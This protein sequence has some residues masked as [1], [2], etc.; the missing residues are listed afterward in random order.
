[1]KK[2]IVVLAFFIGFNANAGLINVDISNPTVSVGGTTELSILGAGFDPF[3]TFEFQL[4]FDTSLFSIDLVSMVSDL[5][6]ASDFIFEVT[7]Q[8]YG[9]ALSFIN[10][11]LFT[12][13]EFIAAKINLTAIAKG[14]TSFNLANVIVEDF[15]GQGPIDFDI[16]GQLPAGVDV[17]GAV[18]APATLGLFAV[19][20]TAFAGFRRKA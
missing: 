19:A 9:I 16:D 13:S 12:S 15:Y 20:L 18:P 5:G 1:M 17:T 4:E 11:D 3:D 7:E 10:F 6:D 2:L 8:S 14:S